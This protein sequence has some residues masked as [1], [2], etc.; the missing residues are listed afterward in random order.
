MRLAMAVAD[1][2]STPK[3]SSSGSRSSTA[4]QLKKS[5]TVAPAMARLNSSGLVMWPI[6]TIVF[7]TVVPMLAPMMTGMAPSMESV[8]VATRVTVRLVVVEELWTRLVTRMP[9]M[10]PSSGV[11]VAPLSRPSRS[12]ELFEIPLIPVPITS[13]AITNRNSTAPSASSRTSRSPVDFGG[14]G[15]AGSDSTPGGAGVTGAG[16]GGSGRSAMRTGRVGRAKVAIPPH[17]PA[18]R[19]RYRG[20]FRRGFAR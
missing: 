1:F 14:A 4:V 10:R 16:S 2:E 20:R 5:C 8:P 6:E 11:L 7:V 19:E 17:A 3:A 15:T 9:V 18:L 12:N 13:S